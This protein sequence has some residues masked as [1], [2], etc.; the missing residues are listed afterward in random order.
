MR[1]PAET[2]GGV[3]AWWRWLMPASGVMVRARG[4]M[5]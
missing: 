5:T 4:A 2:V 1:G 3:V